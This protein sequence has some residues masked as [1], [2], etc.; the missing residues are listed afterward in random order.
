MIEN[1]ANEEIIKGENKVININDPQSPYYLCSS[2]HPR[3]VISPV[4][5]DGDHYA[6][7]SRVV[8]NAL[9]SK[10]KF[11]FVNGDI[12]KPDDAFPDGHA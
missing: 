4:I 6:N 12:A 7:W 2:D 3:N 11:D 9:K 10:H 5:L 1:K 8:I